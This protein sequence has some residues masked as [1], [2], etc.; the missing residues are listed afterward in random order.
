MFIEVRAQAAYRSNAEQFAYPRVCLQGSSSSFGSLT[1]LGLTKVSEP[2]L[3][4]PVRFRT[5]HKSLVHYGSIQFRFAV[6]FF[7]LVEQPECQVIFSYYFN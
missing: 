5:A 1:E 4:R 7:G 2:F 3:T 6:Q